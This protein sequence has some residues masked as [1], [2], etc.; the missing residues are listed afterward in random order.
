MRGRVP[1][2]FAGEDRVKRGCHEGPRL[3][4]ILRTNYLGEQSAHADRRDMPPARFGFA[5][6]QW[7]AT[8][9]FRKR[10]PSTTFPR[11]RAAVM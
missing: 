5:K 7:D 10:S 3:P 9:D 6:P 8:F 4:P 1:R 2:W 11:S